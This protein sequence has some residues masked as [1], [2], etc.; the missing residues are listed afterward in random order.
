MAIPPE[1]TGTFS[2]TGNSSSIVIP[3]KGRLI[4]T[5]AGTAT[6]NLQEEYPVSTWT[7]T[8]DTWTASTSVII[9]GGNRNL[10]LNCSA[11][12]NNVVYRI[13]RIPWAKQAA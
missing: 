10:R 2:A 8:G 6:V 13:A 11:H 7:N 9:D 4:L 12:T 3:G 5:F 1:V